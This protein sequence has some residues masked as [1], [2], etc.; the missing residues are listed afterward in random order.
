VDVIAF[1]T[2]F[3]E[4]VFG[5]VPAL[6]GPGEEI[7]TD[8]FAF[9]CGGG[10]VTVATAASR[11]GVH[12][13][14]SALLGDD[15][16]SRVVEQHCRRAGVDL[17]PSRYVSGPVTGVS[18]AV[19]FGGNRAFIS[20]L[21][22]HPAADRRDLGRWLEVLRAHR[23]RW[24]Y[25]HARPGVAPFIT[26]AHSLGVQVAVDVALG[27]I[28]D[29]PGA[30]ID[31]ARQADVFLP[32]EEE[33]LALTRAGSFGAAVDMAVTWCRC[34]VVT[35]GANG[36][37]VA[38]PGSAGAGA[39]RGRAQRGGGNSRARGREQQSAGAGTAE[40]GGGNSNSTHVREGIAPGPARDRTGAGDAFAGALI[41]ALCQ[42][43][44]IT[45]AAVA[46]NVAGSRT[47][48]VLG[49][50][51]EVAMDELWVMPPPLASVLHTRQHT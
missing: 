51:G 6:P 4:V 10:A 49:A 13:G 24:C 31:C 48:S 1:G 23:P 30:V 36:A 9:S 50:V 45:E 20:H 16:G 22:P 32:N 18:V 37:V 8:Q 41:G 2:V 38:Q 7:Y 15:L 17:T 14:M 42:G 47:V 5:E 29:D 26:E 3:L 19:N 34:V 33:L 28:A 40:R 11:L 35:R 12:A 21:P 25:V 27:D 43:A 39:A 46:G 44:P